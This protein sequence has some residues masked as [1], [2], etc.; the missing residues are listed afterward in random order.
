M[1]I[2]TAP[3]VTTPWGDDG[4]MRW[5]LYDINILGDVAVCPWLDEPFRP[6]ISYESALNIG[7]TTTTVAINKD[8]IAQSN[9]R[10]SIFHNGELLAFGMTDHNGFANVAFD[11]PLNVA[12]TLQMI[13]TGPN[14]IPQ[15]INIIGLNA[16]TAFVYPQNIEL[17]NDFASGNSIFMDVDFKNAGTADANNVTA[18]L[19]TLSQ[20]V[21]LSKSTVEV[22]TV[23]AGTSVMVEDAFDFDVANNIPD[24]TLVDFMMACTDGNNTWNRNVF[25]KAKAPSLK[26][27][28]IEY[29]EIS[30]NMNG[31]LD[32]GET[33]LFT[34]SGKNEGHMM[35]SNPYIHGSSDNQFVTYHTN[36]VSF[37]DVAVG[38]NFEAEILL[39]IN[40]NT[41]QGTAIEFNFDAITGEY[42]S[43]GNITLCVGL[44]TED[45]ETGDL[46]KLQWTLTGDAEW[47][48]TAEQAHSGTFSAQCGNI[49][50]NQMTS[51]IV[52]INTTTDGTL[53]FYF[54]T[55]TKYKKDYL[56]FY[57]DDVVMDFWSGD[58]DW[59]LATFTIEAGN[60]ILEWRYDTA[61][62]G[63]T[64]GNVCWVDDITFPGNT[65]ILDETQ[66]VAFNEVTVY[67]NPANDVI[68]IKGNDVKRVEIYNTLGVKVI[69][70]DVNNSQ[71]IDMTG[72][73]TGMYFLRTVDSKGNISTT[74]VIKK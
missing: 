43:A 68:F 42:T 20:Y 54:K 31:Y 69:S 7:A 36:D 72:F 66:E 22:G 58:N 61:T 17:D 45:F 6:Q 47:F 26:I 38:A 2:M 4:A 23:N 44:I 50:R 53:S 13:I 59:T 9:F 1:K 63:A 52:E 35:A 32:P 70:R 73:A 15:T 62:S 51:L 21:S 65:L 67:P 25:F 28:N 49:E 16:N 37:N 11:E 12:D 5:N 8:G 30:G 3:Y 46:S 14:A 27:N 64:D 41:P 71:S 57:L 74:K 39:T 33:F 29:T 19:T 56:I 24:E 60:H 18:T 48:V 40:E 34:I 10:C 55:L